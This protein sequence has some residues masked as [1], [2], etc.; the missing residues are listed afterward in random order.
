M[1]NKKI[2]LEM[3]EIQFLSIIELTN[4]ISGML[5]TGS[6]FDNL[7]IEVQHVDKMLRANGYKRNFK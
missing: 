5:G 6:D 1:A 4:T 2:K 3:T 7:S